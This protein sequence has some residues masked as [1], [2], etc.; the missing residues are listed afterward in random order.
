MPRYHG[1]VPVSDLLMKLHLPSA[2]L[3]AL[4]LCVNGALAEDP[5]PTLPTLENDSLGYSSVKISDDGLVKYYYLTQQADYTA[6]HD[7]FDNGASTVLSVGAKEGEGSLSVTGEGTVVRTAGHLFIG[8]I[9]YGNE[10][11]NVESYTPHNGYVYV[12]KGATLETAAHPGVTSTGMAQLNVDGT[13]INGVAGQGTLEVDGGTVI[14]NGMLNVGLSQGSDATMTVHSGGHVTL[15]APDRIVSNNGSTP[16]QLVVGFYEGS[17]GSLVLDQSSLEI[18]STATKQQAADVFVGA[19]GEGEMLVKNGSQVDL[20]TGYGSSETHVGGQESGSISVDNSTLTSGTTFVGENAEGSLSAS[21]NA[22]V[23]IEGI[24][25]AGE[26]AR[27]KGTISVSTGA[28]M[29]FQQMVILGGFEE[30]AT[31]ELVISEGGHAEMDSDLYLGYISGA[32]GTV[33]VEGSGSSLSTAGTT[34][35]GAYG[36]GELRVDEGAQASLKTLNVMGSGSSVSVSNGADLSVEGDMTVTGGNSVSLTSSEGAESSLTVEGAYVNAGTTTVD[37]TKG[38]SFSAAGVANSGEMIITLNQDSRFETAAF[39]NMGETTI[40]AE[41]GSTCDLGQVHLL[42]G[43]MKLEGAVE[44]EPLDGMLFSVTG[45]SAENIT[46]TFVD[47]T[48]L[49]GRQFTVNPNASYVL[50]FADDLLA[51]LPQQQE[52]SITLTLIKGYAGFTISEE[53]LATMLSNTGYEPATPGA[54]G[55]EVADMGYAIEGDNLVWTG[56]V[57]VVPE[58]ATATLSLLALVALAARRRRC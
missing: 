48:A 57:K 39:L 42:S 36:Q 3:V 34:Y 20:T 46:S 28:T 55:I 35:V 31:G 12:G 53:A 38:G 10:D 43:S 21:H 6:S 25:Y 1:R 32:Q 45:S 22:V 15:H 9:G 14:A 44:M 30:G 37:L 18:T 49:E 19:K 54:L 52:Q 2:L 29:D 56:K 33:A 40:T 41:S 24:T 17:K 27:G 5:A 51:A 11:E 4:C 50:R 58:P 26:F 8:G 47:V 7:Y 16:G 13:T 23:T